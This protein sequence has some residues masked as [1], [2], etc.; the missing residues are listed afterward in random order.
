MGGF[1]STSVYRRLATV[2]WA[3]PFCGFAI[4]A[5][6]VCPAWPS[7]TANVV[8]SVVFLSAPLLFL[9]GLVCGMVSLYGIREY[10][11]WGILLPA[12]AGILLNGVALLLVVALIVGAFTPS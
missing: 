7:S 12:V 9:S 8:F 6:L 3:S 2:S 11:D 5:S 10:A 1:G 4:F